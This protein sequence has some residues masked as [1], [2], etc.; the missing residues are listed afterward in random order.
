MASSAVVVAFEFGRV[1][2][3]DT[4]LGG[5]NGVDVVDADAGAANDA[6]PLGAD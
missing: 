4:V 2:D 6:Q 3:E 5:A 1:A